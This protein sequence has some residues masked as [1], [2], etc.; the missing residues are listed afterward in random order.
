LQTVT[1]ELEFNGRHEL[2]N[3][4]SDDRLRASQDGK[5]FTRLRW[6][7]PIRQYRTMHG[8][9]VASIGEAQWYAAEREG[10][11]TYL[12]FHV[13]DIGYNVGPQALT[14]RRPS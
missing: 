4:V 7:T 13:E 9:K 6:N 8:R 10:H 2:I 12:D 5:S 14:S 1:A 11:F 3:F